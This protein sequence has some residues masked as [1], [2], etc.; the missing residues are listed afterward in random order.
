[1]TDSYTIT[2]RDEILRV[3]FNKEILASGDR[4]VRDA[5]AQL[6]ALGAAGQLNGGK[7][8]EIDGKMSLLVSYVLAHKLSH[9]YGAIAISDPRLQA[10]IVVKS[11]TP[12]YPIASRIDWATGEVKPFNDESLPSVSSFEIRWEGNILKA[13]LNGEVSVEGDRIV[14]DTYTQLQDLIDAG[15]LPG[16]KQPL[17]INGRAPI[18]TGFAIASRVAHL[19]RTVAVFDPKIGESGS[20]QYV[21]VIDHGGYRVGETIL[22]PLP[23]QPD[24]PAD[25]QRER[26]RIEAPS[27]SPP[28][29]STVP[30]STVSNR[31]SS[32][33]K[34]VICGFPN[35]GKT[36]LHDGLKK[37]L[38]RIPDVRDAYVISGC[39][40]GEGSWFSEIA[41]HNPE[42]ARKLKDEYKTKFTPEFAAAKAQE[43]A[44]IANSLLVFDVGGKLSAENRTIMSQATHAVILAKSDAEVE[45]WQAFCRELDLPV[46]AILYS[47][48]HGTSDCVATPEEYRIE[49]EFPILKGSVHHLDR[50]IDASS[51]PMVRELARVLVNLAIAQRVRRTID[52]SRQIS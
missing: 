16:G 12:D 22:A 51:R 38:H 23:P 49:G 39:P 10:Y 47:D 36:C 50:T 2:W 25:A 40:D 19:Y 44:A 5:E 9:L 42:L 11:D 13:Q 48:Y 24:C 6:E 3:G 32:L 52:A 33:V 18:T 34:A 17:L 37:A 45:A 29:A 41:R 35:T 8:I 46:V 20:E 14:R 7:L 26:S 27:D 28:P 15:Q 4:I 43:I 21:V 1:M 31:S 30:L